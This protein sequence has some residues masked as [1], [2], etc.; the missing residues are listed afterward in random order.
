MNAVV[1]EC[2]IFPL[3]SAAGLSVEKLKMT[4]KGPQHDRTWM[5]VHAA[6]KN[7]G[8]FITQRDRGSEKLALVQPSIH[9][10]GEISFSVVGGDKAL[11]LDADLFFEHEGNVE[12]WGDSCPA[13]DGGDQAA[14]WFSNYLDI[15]CRL[16]KMPDDYKRPV[17]AQFSQSADQVSLADGFPLLITNMASLKSLQTHFPSGENIGMD[18]FRANIVLDG[19]DAF[20]EDVIHHIR[21]GEVEL[22]FVKPCSRCKLTTVDQNQGVVASKEPLASL[23]KLRR[24]KADGLQG[25]FFGQN[26]IARH[27]GVIQKGDS[28]EILSR[29][30]MH[31]ALDQAVLKAEI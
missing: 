24:G 29:K 13:I 14:E 11:H 31:P 26:A 18:R 28:V 7:A 3:K 22:E 4:A 25:V 15:P 30:A 27:L 2:N 6:E 16:V 9:N 21:I 10:N 19:I 17:D 1:S 20:E 23:A 8:K 12:I 5:L